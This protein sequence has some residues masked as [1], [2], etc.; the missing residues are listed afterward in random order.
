MMDYHGVC[1]RTVPTGSGVGTLS[2]Q[3]MV[4]FEVVIKS[5]GG[6][7]L[8]Q[9]VHQ[10]EWALWIQRLLPLLLHFLC[11]LR[12]NGNVGSQLPDPAMPSSPMG[13]FPLET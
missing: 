1:V 5:L 10:F 13:M 2:P 11:F 7:V 12:V 4:L 9:E 3:S 6:G 8:L